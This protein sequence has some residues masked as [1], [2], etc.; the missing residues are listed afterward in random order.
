[1]A[2]YDPF[3]TYTKDSM[4]GLTPASDA[5]PAKLRPTKPITRAALIPQEFEKLIEEQGCRVRITPAV[6]CP[7]RTEIE[8]TNHALDCLVC[9]GSQVVDLDASAVIDWAFIQ[10][11]KFDKKF[12]V[13]GILDLKDA[14][15]S[16]KAKIRIYYWYKIEVLDF[17]SIYNQVIKRGA[18][19]QDTLRYPPSQN[20]P[21]TPYHLIDNA[22]AIYVFGT[23]FDIQP[24]KKLNWLTPSRPAI[25]KLYSV[26]YP[27]LPT[28]RVLEMMHENR[29]YYVDFKQKEKVP[30]QLPQQ[31]L[32]RWD[33]I[34]GKNTARL[35]VP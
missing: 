7:N 14:A 35:E 3:G 9:N 16:I 20:M 29:Y 12:E 5:R 10:S 6:I 2:P 13:Q 28:F 1:M 34:A 15:M 24:N 21:D 30:V 33:Y 22:G 4:A 17:S 23:D 18:G 26:S 11:V 32:I 25:G 31:A 19:D 8:D 27:I